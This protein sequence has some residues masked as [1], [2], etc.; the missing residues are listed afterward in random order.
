MFWS[1]N[2]D[3]LNKIMEMHDYTDACKE[4]SILQILSKIDCLLKPVSK[5]SCDT[6]N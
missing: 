2:E 5:V 4:K 6:M 1:E 3:V